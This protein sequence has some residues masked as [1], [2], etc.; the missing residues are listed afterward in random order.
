MGE[1][2]AIG[3][4]VLWALNSVLVRPLALRLPAVR[5]TAL[6]YLC[7]AA[8]MLVTAAALGKLPVAFQIPP[9]QAAG[10]MGSAL[11][12][13]GLGDTSYVR[14]LS[15]IGVSRAYPIS[16]ASYV[17]ATF[18]LAALL[19]GEAVTP[20]TALG[21]ALLLVGIWVISRSS[22]DS[23]LGAFDPAAVRRG[24]LIA[25][26]A[27][28]C[29]GLTTTVLKLAVADTDLLAANTLRVPLVALALN[30]LA[31]V[32][33]G[34]GYAG[35]GRRGV[36]VAALAGVVGLWLSSLLFLYAVQEAGAAKTAVLSSTSPLFA[37]A[38]AVVFLHERVT[39]ALG[40]GTVLAVAGMLA[41][42]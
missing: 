30:G 24:I 33:F 21:A 13:M 41:T 23:G 42:V 2:A 34:P 29:W 40:V 17:L 9:L 1:L 16:Q 6:Q 35:F 19:A 22:H 38:L 3:S 36:A 25:L 10:L 8:C 27:G 20:A 32:R 5:I 11:T 12:G 28:V 26:F 4:A 14:S 31:A 18:A 15:M 37:S 39:P 7:S